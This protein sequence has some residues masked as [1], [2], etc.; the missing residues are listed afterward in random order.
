MPYEANPRLVFERMF[1]GRTPVVPNWSRRA[2]PRPSEV[3]QSAKPRFRRA[4]RRRSGAGRGEDLRG[5]LGRGDQRK[6]DEYLR[7]GALDREADRVRRVPPAPGG[8]GRADPGPSKLTLPANLPAEGLP[9]WKVTQ[10]V[11]RDPEK[12]AEYIRL[13]ADL[14]VL[15]FQ[16]DT[17]RVATLAVG[18][19]EA[20]FPGVVTVGYE[21]HCHTLEHQGNAGRPRTPTRSP[22]R[23]AGRSTPGTPCCSPRWSAR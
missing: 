12:H 5:K 17:T 14:M 11:D 13:M 2:P 22:A 23:P 18:S 9:I 15:A 19:D 20:L 7:R 8:A 1:R 6:L 10:P 21:R 3:R 16:T 4:E